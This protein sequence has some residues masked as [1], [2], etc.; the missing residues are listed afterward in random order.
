LRSR[1]IGVPLSSL[2]ERSKSSRL[3][4]VEATLSVEKRARVAVSGRAER[5]P[6][7]AGRREGSQGRP[8]AAR[9]GSLDGPVG[10]RS[11]NGVRTPPGVR[12][13]VLAVLRLGSATSA[14]GSGRDGPSPGP[15][16]SRGRQRRGSGAGHPFAAARQAWSGA[17]AAR[18]AQ[19]K[20]DLAAR[21][22]M[23][24]GGLA[25]WLRP[26]RFTPLRPGSGCDRR[27]GRRRRGG[28][29]CGRRPP[30]RCCGCCA[31][32]RC[33]GSRPGGTCRP[34]DG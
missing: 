27:A 33:A 17:A 23:T 20:G 13:R 9:R 29:V 19:S 11:H 3:D 34:V 2:K 21:G 16:G 25:L 14:W 15:E 24:H 10:C 4:E 32:R 5:A 8:Q 1:R 6:W 31:V 7:S 12:G 22:V 28:R 18:R 30:E 26:I